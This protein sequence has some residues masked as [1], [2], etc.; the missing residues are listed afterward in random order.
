MSTLTT[1]IAGYKVVVRPATTEE[2][3]SHKATCVKMGWSTLDSRGYSRAVHAS[4]VSDTGDVMDLPYELRAT[5][6]TVNPEFVLGMMASHVED[7]AERVEY[8]SQDH[9]Y[10]YAGDCGCDE[11][12]I[13]DA[14][15]F[16]KFYALRGS[17]NSW[18][19]AGRKARIGAKSNIEPPAP[20]TYVDVTYQRR[21]GRRAGYA[22]ENMN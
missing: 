11:C 6:M 8:T 18:N 4:F 19:L 22:W 10:H 9:G 15:S 21:T 16:R 14:M 1:R 17:S 20:E 2:I 5:L 7:L 3:E 12:M 13:A